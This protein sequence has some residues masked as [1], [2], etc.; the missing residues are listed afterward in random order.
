MTADIINLK[1]RRPK[2]VDPWRYNQP[3]LI[4]KPGNRDELWSHPYFGISLL[5]W[6]TGSHNFPEPPTT[7][8]TP[9]AAN[10][11]TYRKLRAVAA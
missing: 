4:E 6:A 5:I 3:T 10:V 2:P 9:A 11:A 8:G 1:D 7:G